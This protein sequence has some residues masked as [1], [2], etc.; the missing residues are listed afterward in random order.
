MACQNR[1]EGKCFSC[2][3][4]SKVFPSKR[5]LCEHTRRKHSSSLPPNDKAC[6]AGDGDNKT[7]LT[8]APTVQQPQST[9]HSYGQLEPF[10]QASS[11]CLPDAAGDFLGASSSFSHHH[12]HHQQ[13]HPNGLSGHLGEKAEASTADNVGSLM[14]LVYGNSTWATAAGEEEMAGMVE[15][16]ASPFSCGGQTS[17]ADAPPPSLNYCSGEEVLAV[18]PK[19]AYSMHVMQRGC[20]PEG[21]PQESLFPAT[22]S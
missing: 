2:D 1:S 16:V 11:S 14:R 15:D 3:H 22:V 8:T 7:R 19:D 10:T 13:M 18:C 12:H 9:Y 5:H 4:C 6:S 17:A 20:A 21:Q